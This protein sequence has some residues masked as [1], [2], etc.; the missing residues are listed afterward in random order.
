MASYISVHASDR[1]TEPKA[2]S[3]P[4]D[5]S[6][7]CISKLSARSHDDSTSAT[8]ASDHVLGVQAVCLSSIAVVTAAATCVQCQPG[9]AHGTD[10]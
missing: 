8:M 10:G 5:N 1:H 4:G 2:C 7:V 9:I 3:I 6:Y